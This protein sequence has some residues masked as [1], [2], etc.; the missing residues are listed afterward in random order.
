MS[1][2]VE[3]P[4]VVGKT[5]TRNLGSGSLV[6]KLEVVVGKTVGILV[7]QVSL[8]LVMGNAHS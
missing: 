5:V 7:S 3:L 1:L 6:V 8:D 4:V 2:V